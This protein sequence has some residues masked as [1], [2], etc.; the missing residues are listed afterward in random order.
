MQPPL[1]SQNVTDRVYR[2]KVKNKQCP[3]SP[4]LSLSSKNT[5]QGY[6]APETGDFDLFARPVTKYDLQCQS[7]TNTVT[8]H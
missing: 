2:K 7:F 6:F 1:K 8:Q 3:S 5:P 4:K